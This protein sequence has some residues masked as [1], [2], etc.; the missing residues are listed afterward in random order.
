MIAVLL[1]NKFNIFFSLDVLVFVKRLL[2]VHIENL[3]MRG[4]IFIDFN[5]KEIQIF[6][7]Y[8]LL[9][10]PHSSFEKK[11]TKRTKTQIIKSKQQNNKGVK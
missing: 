8:I 4:N 2:T 1:N 11:N 10:Q 9:L 5:E 7:L 3:K 6:I